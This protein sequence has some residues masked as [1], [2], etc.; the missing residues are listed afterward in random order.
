MTSNL[1]DY[2]FNKFHKLFSEL[3]GCVNF[4]ILNLSV[5]VFVCIQ[6]ACTAILQEFISPHSDLVFLVFHVLFEFYKVWNV[7]LFMA[8]VL[9]EL[10]SKKLACEVFEQVA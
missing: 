3:W 2:I 1:P 5:R 6:P 4:G 9:C 8:P 10:I 7:Q